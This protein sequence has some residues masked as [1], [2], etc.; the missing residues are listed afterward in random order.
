VF[1]I[2]LLLF[3]IA[4]E[5]IPRK[6]PRVPHVF[7]IIVTSLDSTDYK[8]GVQRQVRHCRR[9]RNFIYYIE[10]FRKAAG[11]LLLGVSC[12]FFDIMHQ[13]I[14]HAKVCVSIIYNYHPCWSVTRRFVSQ[15]KV[16]S[17]EDLPEGDLTFR[18]ETNR[19]DL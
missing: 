15:R 3:Q 10:Y 2:L 16:R 5:E 13:Y 18:G 7:P 14:G 6:F 12:K 4:R 19:R 1:I 8:H 17:P 9:R 11:I